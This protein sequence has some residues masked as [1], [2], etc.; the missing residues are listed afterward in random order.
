MYRTV[1]VSFQ[2]ANEDILEFVKVQWQLSDLRE[3]NN[4]NG[5]LPRNLSR[6]KF[7]ILSGNYILQVRRFS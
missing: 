7:V 2:P 5:S 1:H 4:E 6:Q 3:T